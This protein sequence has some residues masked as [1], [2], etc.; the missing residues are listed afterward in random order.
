MGVLDILNHLFNFA[1]PAF[2]MALLLP[3]FGRLGARGKG[4]R[5]GWKMQFVLVFGVG[6]GVL[7]AGLWIFGHDGKM[8]TYAGM[9]LV[10]A[11]TQWGMQRR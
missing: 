7:L 3:I 8:A 1:A 5:V 4:A 2:G 6:L 10:C 11:T 9:V